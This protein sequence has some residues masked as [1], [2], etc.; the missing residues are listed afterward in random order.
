MPVVVTTGIAIGEVA[1]PV[2]QQLFLAPA[3]V[4][5]ERIGRDPVEPGRKP[6][7][8]PKRIEVAVSE[9]EGFLGEVVGKRVI[10]RREP[11]QR[12]AHR[13]LV[14]AHELRER[15]AVIVNDNARNELGIGERRLRNRGA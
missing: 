9:H 7:L 10:P 4:G 14:A 12:R 2:A 3:R 5:Q 13:G 8:V 6:R 15:M 11:P 1:V